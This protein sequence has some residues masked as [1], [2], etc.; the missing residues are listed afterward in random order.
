M[1]ANRA[2][3]LALLC[4]VCGVGQAEDLGGLKTSVAVDTVGQYGLNSGTS[5]SDRLDVR[6]AELLLYAPADHLFDGQ[7]NIAAHTEAGVMRLEIH[8]A[9]IGSSKL[10]ARSRFR[11]GHF[12]LGVGRL[13]QIHRHD[14]P[15][16]TPPKYHRVFFADEAAQD[17]GLE[18]TYL[19]PTSF[20]LELTAGLTSGFTFGHDHTG[21]SK[22]K[23]P[24]HYLRAVTYASLPWDGGVQIGANYV[25]RTDSG[26]TKNT[27]IGFDLAAKWR[28]AQVLKC[29]IQSEAWFQT[30]GTQT[31]WGMYLY[32]E[33]H[34][35]G[36]FFLGTRFDYY[37]ISN[38]KDGGGFDY[39][40]G[41]LSLVPTL[42]YRNS[43]FA[44]FRLAF[45]QSFE[46]SGST[47]Q[48]NKIA[49]L[50][51]VFFLG[52]HPAHDF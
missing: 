50:Q 26:D 18:Y 44:L 33:F 4:F 16:I 30:L 42:T 37:T 48:S 51:A 11:L 35:G 27:L 7:L 3:L 24:T 52:A 12:F 9:Y 6:E 41:T 40:N 29:L 8:E 13:N 20:F 36:N 10:V 2:W 39:A 19:L 21:G 31:S 46:Q 45:T 5:A 17:T 23:V 25:S 1:G 22:P 32:P 28:E 15:F 49:E 47:I 34:L 43:E 14:W 38:L